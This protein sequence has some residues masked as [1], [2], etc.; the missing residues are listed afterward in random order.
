MS[1][2]YSPIQE[3][4]LNYLKSSYG[5]IGSHIENI[6][7]IVKSD[8]FNKIEI[9]EQN[10]IA[11]ELSEINIE[12]WNILIKLTPRESD[13]EDIKPVINRLSDDS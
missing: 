8:E 9:E 4:I 6:T 3:H 10:Y 5:N 2:D 1:N 11:Q 13:K 7:D 12:L